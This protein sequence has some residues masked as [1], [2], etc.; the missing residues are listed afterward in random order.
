[1]PLTVG[2]SLAGYISSA[3]ERA[4]TS[5]S[6][7]QIRRDWTATCRIAFWFPLS[8]YRVVQIEKNI[9]MQMH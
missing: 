2:F 5:N 8:Q 9:Y 7:L 4:N 1:M 3:Y 6:W